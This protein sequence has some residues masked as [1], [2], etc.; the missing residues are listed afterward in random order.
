MANRFLPPVPTLLLGGALL[1]TAVAGVFLTRSPDTEG[2]GQNSVSTLDRTA[3]PGANVFWPGS[4]PETRRNILAAP[5]F[6]EDRRLPDPFGSTPSQTQQV[7]KLTAPDEPVEEDL[8]GMNPPSHM[9]IERVEER[10]EEIEEEEPEVINKP[11]DLPD[12]RLVGTLVVEGKGI[13]RA[14][15]VEAN[16][17]GEEI[18]VDENGTYADWVLK[19]VSPAAVLLEAKDERRTLEMWVESEKVLE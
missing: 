13:A 16:G 5:L 3:E 19:I 7:A 11:L 14:L 4:D 17:T 8:L 9:P 6:A 2:L 18:W 15:L 10:V 1:V 12:L